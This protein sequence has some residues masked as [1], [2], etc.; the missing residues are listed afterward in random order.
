[1][2]WMVSKKKKDPRLI[3][4]YMSFIF[5]TVALPFAFIAVFMDQMSLFLVFMLIA[6][7]LMLFTVTPVNAVFLNCV[8]PE[9]RSHSVAIATLSIHLLGDLSSP[10]IFG[11]ISDK[12]GN[13]RYSLFFLSCWAIWTC[14]FWGFASLLIAR[15]VKKENATLR[16][17]T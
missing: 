2:D 1:M 5:S 16:V 13:Q 7:F 6:E 14:L 15:L 4:V 10:Y 9:L 17:A 11:A 8:P 3:G 12:T